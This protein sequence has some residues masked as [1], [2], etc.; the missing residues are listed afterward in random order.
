MEERRLTPLL[1]QVYRSPT[2]AESPEH[3]QVPGRSHFDF[4]RKKGGVEEITG[5]SKLSKS[6]E[7]V[8]QKAPTPASPTENKCTSRSKNAAWL[9]H[10]NCSHPSTHAGD[11]LRSSLP[12]SSLSLPSPPAPS[13]SLCPLGSSLTWTQ[14]PLLLAPSTH[15]PWSGQG[16]GKQRVPGQLSLSARGGVGEGSNL[17]LEKHAHRPFHSAPSGH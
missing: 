8:K 6:E 11:L 3:K 14:P 16:E 12:P 7:K 9:L 13:P 4:R 10:R 5:S 17:A 1:K 15:I 2:L